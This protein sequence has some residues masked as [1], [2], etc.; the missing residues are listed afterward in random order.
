M[1]SQ[2]LVRRPTHLTLDE[3]FEYCA[4]I[5]NS[6]YENFPVASLFLPKEQRPYVQAIYAFSRVADDMADELV[7]PS[8][9]RLADLD[10]WEDNLKRCYQGDAD[11]PVFIALADTVSKL[12]IPFELLRSLLTAFRRD[13][14]QRR[15]ETFED[16]LS[17]CACSANPVGRI[18]L[19]IFGYRDEKSFLLSDKICTALQLTNF[20]QDVAIDQ[21][22]DRLYLPLEDC[23]SHGYSIE[24]WKDGRVD[25]TFRRLMK[26]ETERT[27]DLFYAG[28]ELP[29]IV[30]KDLQVELKLVWFGGMTILKKLERSKFDVFS[31][32]PT[33]S[34]LD[35]MS[36]LFRGLFLNNLRRPKKKGDPW[37]LTR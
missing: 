15:Y 7:R 19:T 2:P 18:V 24:Q 31:H 33:L 3:A 16:L 17:Y 5:T 37:D 28:A 8:A 22:K 10:A 9:E 12:D 34:S 14:V 35:K 26:F 4:K 1:D 25:D 13:V 6:H 32:R 36:V 20:W 21:Q 30:D 27:R 29:F 23:L 11:H